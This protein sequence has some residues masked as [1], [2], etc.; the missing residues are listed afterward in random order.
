MKN[1][2][3][4]SRVL[5]SLALNR[6]VSGAIGLFTALVLNAPS[7]GT[8]AVSGGGLR[9]GASILKLDTKTEGPNFTTI[10]NATTLLD[11]KIGY[12]MSNGLYIGAIYNMRTDETNGSKQERSGYGATVGYHVNGWFI[13][14]TYFLNSTFK[15][16]GG[17]ELSGGSGFGIDLGHNFDIAT[18]VYLGVQLSYKSFTYTKTQTTDATNKI[19]SELAPMLN[20]GVMF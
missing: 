12:V 1:A 13:D 6:L 3:V 11:A 8:S 7:V 4:R 18:N 14:G 5:G 9:I 19:T 16:A 20:I 15:F 10:D 17:S 2:S